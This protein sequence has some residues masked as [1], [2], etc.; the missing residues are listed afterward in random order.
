MILTHFS[1][2]DF[3]YDPARSYSAKTRDNFKPWGLWLSDENAEMSWKKWCE[4]ASFGLER[5][6]KEVK[7]ECDTSTWA[8]LKNTDEI[9]TFSRKYQYQPF[10]DKGIPFKS[11][12][13]EKIKTEYGGVLITPYNWECRMGAETFWYYGWDCASRF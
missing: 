12:D 1:H 13:W 2:E 4:G 10:A 8:V 5:L 3:K 11:L 7:F 9:L 6:K